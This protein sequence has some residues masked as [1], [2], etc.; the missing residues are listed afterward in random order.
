[1][2]ITD[3]DANPD[4]T[5]PRRPKSSA[6]LEVLAVEAVT[7]QPRRYLPVV[8]LVYSALDFDELRLSVVV[9][10][11]ASEPH[12]RA[13]LEA[14]GAEKLGITIAAPVGEPELPA[15][16]LEQRTPYDTVRGLQK[17]AD[18]TPPDIPTP[19][20]DDTPHDSATARAELAALSVRAVPAF[21]HRELL[22]HALQDT[23]RRFL[24]VTSRLRD[25]VI[26]HDLIAQLERMLRRRG[27]VAYIAYGLGHPD[28]EHDTNAV[29]HLKELDERFPNLTLVRL[30]DVLPHC[31]IFDDT[32][33]NS[34]FDWFSFRG[35]Q[36]RTYRREEGTLISAANIVN[37]RFAEAAAGVSD[38]V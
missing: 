29:D 10:D 7:R 13:L 31:L 9:D 6:K 19:P 27:L 25:A 28:D 38:K 33:I 35:G 2:L 17:R 21:E 32:W 30:R 26:N 11:L 20:R 34:S 1:M 4:P 23:R 12:S 5:P 24:L 8:L 37:D 16:L 36:E 15:Q 14:G 22:E 3:T 18:N